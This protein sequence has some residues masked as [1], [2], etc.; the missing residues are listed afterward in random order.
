MSQNK[1]GVMC[2][3]MVACVS[4]LPVSVA[5]AAE[6]CPSRKLHPPGFWAKRGGN[7]SG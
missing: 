2:V 3:V 7:A 6:A 1:V 5:G 4:M